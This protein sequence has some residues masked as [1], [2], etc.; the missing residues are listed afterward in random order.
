MAPNFGSIVIRF[1]TSPK[2]GNWK[3]Q[4][5]F[6][7][8]RHFKILS[9]SL[10]YR[11]FWKLDNTKI[12][13]TQRNLIITNLPKVVKKWPLQIT[14]K[15]MLFKLAPE[16]QNIWATFGKQICCKELS[17]WPGLPNYVSGVG[18]IGTRRVKRTKQTW[19]SFAGC[20]RFAWTSLTRSKG[21]LLHLRPKNSA[22]L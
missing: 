2:Y 20:C 13:V 17:M 14:L 5:F 3:L 16:S 9:N 11:Y 1:R 22:F 19:E 7:T 10:K 4:N 8:F 21:F 15:W 6:K 18:V 12:T